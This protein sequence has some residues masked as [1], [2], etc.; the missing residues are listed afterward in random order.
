ME[1]CKTIHT[2]LLKALES[3]NELKGKSHD[4]IKAKLDK[5]AEIL[6][7]KTK[8]VR[9]PKVKEL[10]SKE[11]RKLELKEIEYYITDIEFYL[12]CKNHKDN[13]TYKRKCEVAG[14]WYLHLSGVDIAFKS[15]NIDFKQETKDKNIK[16][17]I[18]DDSFF[19]G[20]LLRGIK[21]KDG[22]TLN[23]KYL[24]GHPIL[25]CY[26]LF[27]KTDMYNLPILEEDNSRSNLEIVP[28]KRIGV[29]K[30][31]EFATKPY[32]Y[33]LKESK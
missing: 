20:I 25:I 6:L 23:G 33:T 19:G 15:E 17:G 26:E 10:R 7:T 22:K 9:M 4:E 21:A 24:D 16:W 12:Y 30:N 14:E 27:N 28:G 18:D 1:N 31:S 5:I 13:I 8:I 3:A 29:S 32:R 11:L 2:Y